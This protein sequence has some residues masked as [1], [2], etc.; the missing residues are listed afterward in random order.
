MYH[1][2]LDIQTFDKYNYIDGIN[3]VKC[4]NNKLKIKNLTRIFSSN[5]IIEFEYSKLAGRFR[6]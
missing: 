5:P 3:V 1:D 2:M 4:K 6:K